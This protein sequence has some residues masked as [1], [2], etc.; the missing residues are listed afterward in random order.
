[1]MS[2]KE[3][4]GDGP[5]AGDSGRRARDGVPGVCAVAESDAEMH[6]V[7]ATFGV[8][9]EPPGFDDES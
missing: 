1:M 3:G 7:G 5:S 4:A 8:S 9:A 6:R 2:W